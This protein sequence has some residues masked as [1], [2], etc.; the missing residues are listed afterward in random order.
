MKE[1]VFKRDTRLISLYRCPS[2]CAMRRYCLWTFEAIFLS[3]YALRS[4]SEITEHVMIFS[5]Q[6]AGI[7][8]MLCKLASMIFKIVKISVRSF[9]LVTLNFS[10]LLRSPGPYDS[11]Q[12]LGCLSKSALLWPLCLAKGAEIST[13][14]LTPSMVDSWLPGCRRTLLLQDLLPG[15]PY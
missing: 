3:I 12:F 11:I 2:L 1:A 7:C 8:S 10:V 4:L 9:K 14:P 15:K 13:D 6:L 5:S